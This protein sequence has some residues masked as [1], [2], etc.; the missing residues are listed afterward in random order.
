MFRHLGLGVASLAARP[1]ARLTEAAGTI[2]E[3]PRGF[4]LPP[5]PYAYDALEPHLDA[6]TMEIHH[7]KHHQTYVN[8][9]NA[10]LKNHPDLLGKSVEQ[11]LSDLDAIPE[12]VRIAVRNNGGGHY[13]HLLF[14]TCMTPRV[15]AE[16]TG[17]L[18]DAITK[19]FGSFTGF[20]EQ[21]TTA[22]VKHFGSGWTW[23][24]KDHADELS[25]TTT[26]NQDSPVSLGLTPLLALDVW[27][28][29]YYLKFQNRR[30]EFI[31]AWWNVV[32]WNAVTLGV[33]R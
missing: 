22:A 14:W 4:S 12:A 18:A 20:K 16:P 13:N 17:P 9:L 31:A 11:L 15:V 26:A 5:L 6:R 28:H 23:L 1:L 27:E 33:E 21:F 25:I 19:K 10:A 32:N 24:V 2:E 30:A 7:K 8:N 29:A 3:G